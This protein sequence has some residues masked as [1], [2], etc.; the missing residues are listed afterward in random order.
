MIRK[1][2]IIMLY[3]NKT[4][5]E[6]RALYAIKDAT[7]RNCKFDGP[8][9]GESAFKECRNITVEDC[10][11]NLR[12]PFWHVEGAPSASDAN[13]ISTILIPIRSAYRA[14]LESNP[15]SSLTFDEQSDAI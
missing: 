4:Y 13:S 7:V 11:F 3:E 6:E 10:Y 9:D 14:T 15:S 1:E 12:Y 5:D 2:E 8:A